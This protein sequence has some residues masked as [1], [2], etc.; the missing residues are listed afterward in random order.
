MSVQNSIKLFCFHYI[1]LE[2][3]LLFMASCPGFPF[4]GSDINFYLK[5][6][7]LTKNK[8]Y[9]KKEMSQF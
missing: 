2:S 3:Y 8:K 9:N 5:I 4:T 6:I 1:D 7:D